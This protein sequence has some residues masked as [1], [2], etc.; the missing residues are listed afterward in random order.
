MSSYPTLAQV[1]SEVESGGN[2][3]A[4]RFERG[5]F[6]RITNQGSSPCVDRI[7]RI[8]RCSE[9]TARVIYS[10]SYGLYQIMGF[11]LYGKLSCTAP[12]MWGFLNDTVLQLKM[13]TEYL[14]LNNMDKLTVETLVSD[15]VALNNF[16]AA[17][18][19]PGNVNAYSA[20]IL[21]T[22]KRLTV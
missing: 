17:Y 15:P 2:Q 14:K 20:K 16:S 22:I 10:T 3:F 21:K 5:I 7:I 1:V 18:N 19:G 9:D 11:N 8:H 13:F 4:V 12:Y 6:N